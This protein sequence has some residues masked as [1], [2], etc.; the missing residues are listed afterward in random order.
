ML[1]AKQQE[2]NGG[3]Q[4]EMLHLEAGSNLYMEERVTSLMAAVPV[5][6]CQL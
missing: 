1:E 2:H 5:I 6:R 3:D 4:D